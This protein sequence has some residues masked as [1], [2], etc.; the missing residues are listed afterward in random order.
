MWRKAAKS[1]IQLGNVDSPLTRAALQ[2]REVCNL[3]LWSRHHGTIYSVLELSRKFTKLAVAGH[4]T[5]LLCFLSE[6]R[7]GW[8]L[9][10]LTS[11]S[12]MRRISLRAQDLFLWPQE[13]IGCG[14]SNSWQ[15]CFILLLS[16]HFWASQEQNPAFLGWKDWDVPKWG[17]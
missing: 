5:W 4:I 6:C 3:A 7:A 1:S 10:A 17:F 13:H 8:A 15:E 2:Y 16:N 14:A 9:P 11:C 12:A